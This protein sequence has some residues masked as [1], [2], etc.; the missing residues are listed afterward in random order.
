MTKPIQRKSF[1]GSVSP[2]ALEKES[3]LR[4]LM[5][6]MGRVLV[7]Y[8]GGVDSTYLAAVASEELGADALCVL[9]VSPSVA[10][11]QR[12]RAEESASR[13][14]FNLKIISTDELADPN[15]AANPVNRCYFCKSELYGKLGTL[16]SKEGVAFVLDGTNADDLSDFRPGRRAADEK[17][18]R[19]PLAEVGLTKKEIRELSRCM[20]LP[21]WDMPASPCLSSRIAH[22]D[23]VTVDTLSRVENGENILRGHGFR[24]FRV[25]V[26]GDLARLEISRDE[27]QRALDVEFFKSIVEQF[28][29]IG[30]R[31]VTLDLAGF[32]SGSM[33]GQ[34]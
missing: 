25:R 8:S 16:S 23:P 12:E 20:D 13:F 5:Q 9:G 29:K 17:S 26:H 27:L 34:S 21:T 15:Y 28:K 6:A 4:A 7:A 18:V 14:G 1:D 33:N 31:F 10:G 22:G 3:R 30:F 11:W 24:E 19:S 32:K 2:L